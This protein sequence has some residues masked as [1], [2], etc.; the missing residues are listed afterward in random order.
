MTMHPTFHA[1]N[2][3]DKPAYILADTGEQL[4]FGELERFSNR[5][6]QLFRQL[7]LKTGDHVAVMIENCLEFQHICWAAVRAGLY[8]TP[9]STS[10]KSDE[11]AYIVENCEASVFIASG[12]LADTIDFSQLPVPAGV[13]KFMI[14][15]DEQLVDGFRDWD[16]ELENMSDEPIEDECEG[17]FMMYSSGTTGLPKGIKRPFVQG[18]LGMGNSAGN[19]PAMQKFLYGASS[20]SV[21][22]SPAPLYHAAPLYWASAYTRLGAT[23]VIMKKFEPEKALQFIERFKVTH[24]QWVPTMFVRFLKLE[25]ETRHR[26]DL[27]SLQC[28]VH[29]AAPCP[30]SVKENMINWWGPVVH[31]Y[32]TGSEGNG[33]TVINPKEWLEHKGCVGKAIY[34]EI[35]IVDEAT[36]EELPSGKEGTVYFGGS[37]TFEYHNEEE[38]T[39]NSRHSQGW[40]TLGDVGYV[41]EQGYLYLTDRRTNLI[42]S[43]G[44]NIYP[45]ET[46]N[47]I[48]TL[49][50]VADVAVIGVP[51]EDFG[52]EVKAIVQPQSPELG[53]S[54]SEQQIIDF[55]REH[56]SNI[57]CPRSV[58][59]VQ[60]LP[61]TETG[62]L[63]KRVLKAQYKVKEE[64]TV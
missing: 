29:S 21:F 47:L 42:I 16:A 14:K 49:P 13:A 5:G 61:R 39:Q 55:C 11:I 60:E 24:S 28:A 37:Y 33:M 17:M 59:F 54:L 34:G 43:G 51:N 64:A 25:S 62:K 38:K 40:S 8:F 63:L 10:L 30:T 9:I 26:Y 32:Y 57:K 50:E 52:E 53:A 36:G 12:K 44:V 15:A 46:E 22:L 6:A 35:H 19:Y 56:L 27:S 41:D 31:E 4:T 20:D 1:Q 7:G 45:Q 48:I 18:P 23:V 2:T 3:P 58:E